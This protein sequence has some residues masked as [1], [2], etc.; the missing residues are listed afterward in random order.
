MTLPP[1]NLAS[2]ANI[3]AYFELVGKL[4]W[5]KSLV[6]LNQAEMGKMIG[7]EAAELKKQPRQPKRAR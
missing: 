4:L 5:R 3:V 6:V 7:G 2:R 1:G